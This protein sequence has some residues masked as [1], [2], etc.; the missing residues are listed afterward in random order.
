MDN[1]NVT[2]PV[3][4]HQK[5]ARQNS[6]H[7][8]SES[9][10]TM[11]KKPREYHELEAEQEFCMGEP[12]KL[13]I[14]S[15][16][17]LATDH[18]ES[19][20]KLV[21][22]NLEDSN[23]GNE[24]DS[25]LDYD[26]LDDVAVSS[27]VADFIEDDYVGSDE[28][29]TSIV[30]ST[31]SLSTGSLSSNTASLVG[32]TLESVNLEGAKDI[33]VAPKWLTF[34]P[35]L[36]DSPALR[37]P[38]FSNVSP[39]INF[40]AH[41]EIS[42]HQLPENVRKLLKWKL[43][44]ITPAIVKR[45]TSNS[46]YRLMRKTC[47]DWHAT[48]GKHMKSGLFKEINENQKINHFPGT[49]NIGRKDKLWRNYHRLML[50]H[51]KHEFGFMPRTFVLPGDNK[52]LKK[53]WERRGA[54][55]RWILK[56]PA[57]AR[58]IGISV[59]NKYSKIPKNKPLVVQ[60]Y[61]ARPYLINGT[62]FDLR[63]YLLVTSINPLR[64]YLYEDGL[65]RFASNKYSND[66]KD[67]DDVYM[68]LTN[69]SIN[70]KSS[71]YT[72]NED[73]DSCQG[74]KW[75]LKSLWRYFEA[76]GIDHKVVWEKVK[77]LMIKTVISAESSMSNL[78]KNNV[79]SRYSCYELFGFDILLDSKLKPWLIEV[80]IS[81]SLH[82][83]SSLDLDVKSN[84]S[85]EVFNMARFHIPNKIRGA[86]QRE[87][88]AKLGMPNL[89]AL[90]HDKRLYVKDISKI[91]R[92]KHDSAIEY[93]RSQISTS[94]NTNYVPPAWIL[95]HLTPD[96]TRQLIL[97]EEEFSIC[98]KFSRIFPT[99]DSHRYFKFFEKTR[100][101]NL[102]LSAWEQKYSSK[103]EAGHAAL[104]KLCLQKH[105]LKI[106]ANVY[107]KKTATGKHQTIDISCLAAPT[108]ETNKDKTDHEHTTTTHHEVGEP[109]EATK[110]HETASV[111]QE[112]HHDDFS[113]GACVD[114][115]F[116]NLTSVGARS[117]HQHHGLSLPVILPQQ[118]HNKPELMD[119]SVS[120][121]ECPPHR[122]SS[123]KERSFDETTIDSTDHLVVNENYK[124]IVASS[125]SN[126]ALDNVKVI[127]NSVNG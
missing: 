15:V 14:D 109:H 16:T 95:D 124:K 118:C 44:T 111:V 91:E 41:N 71:T 81:P 49:F 3:S 28:D 7:H 51:G 22:N 69:Y 112:G 87:I 121:P 126:D 100:Y 52:L 63:I 48:W 45:T 108:S 24:S 79:S 9:G 98:K 123:T 19:G 62:K 104:E 6:T 33:K 11:A 107:L 89:L 78:F 70:K 99:P 20:V 67:V 35:T 72:S 61:V 57:L 23:I 66:S 125:V 55:G 18:T 2:N 43:S 82:S 90:C 64:L 38:L 26:D 127:D 86:E 5:R 36:T 102:L 21:A 92:T 83:A 84:L 32:E 96:D 85:V 65:V 119:C 40:M 13:L 114:E 106:P 73:S 39:S 113:S 47:T 37:R 93:F 4:G 101:H 8:G 117:D 17:P 103:R 77:D 75:T 34:T 80:N 12:N 29:D 27:D 60:R 74:H 50:K 58:G 46:G 105:H 76:E 115:S 59:V 56:P 97:A 122:D 94:N 53:V 116:A 31:T 110:I 30:S 25:D 120:P 1:E 42:A 68:H 10:D 54:K 88:G